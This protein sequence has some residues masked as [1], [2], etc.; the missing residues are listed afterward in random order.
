MKIRIYFRKNLKLSP[1]KLAAVC[2][3]LG[4][5]LGI[6]HKERGLDNNPFEDK[7]VILSA[8]D[9]KFKEY[10][11]MCATRYIFDNGSFD[12]HIHVDAGFKEVEA[13]TKCAIGWIEEEESCDK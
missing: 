5:E 6:S 11:S 13:Y 1:Q 3:H 10:E 12:Y 2:T 7:V 4:K 9:A 8:S